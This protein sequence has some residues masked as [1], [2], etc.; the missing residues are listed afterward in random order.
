MARCEENSRRAWPGFWRSRDSRP[1]HAH[2]D[3]PNQRV[4]RSIQA[5]VTPGRLSIDY[6]VSL[7][8]LTLTQDLRS[9][10]GPRP[11]AE[12]SEWLA[13][14]GEVTG[15]LNAKGFLVTV[16]GSPIGLAST[17]YHARGRGASALHVSSSRPPIPARG[18]L[19]IHDTNFVSSEGT[20]RL[21]IR[22]RD[23]VVIEGNDGPTEVDRVPIRPVWELSDAEELRTKQ[24]AV[25][26]SRVGSGTD[27]IGNRSRPRDGAAGSG[28]PPGRA[29]RGA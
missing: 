14:Y 1:F 12:R 19:S 27:E 8:E 9:L 22:G 21:A 2:H 4:D 23:G 20:S 18:R 15:P 17:G 13:L 5:T 3:I 29:D 10:V 7:T 24:I 6:E 11:G 16:D 25:R 26:Y 28:S